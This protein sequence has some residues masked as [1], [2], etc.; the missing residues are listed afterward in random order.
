MV[1][2]PA[3]VAPTL[4]KKGSAPARD[5]SNHLHQNEDI[6]HHDESQPRAEIQHRA[7]HRDQADYR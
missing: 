2:L 6:N 7:K 5:G 4:H 3:P 1:V